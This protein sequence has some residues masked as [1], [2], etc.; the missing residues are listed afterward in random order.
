MAL[1]SAG[2]TGTGGSLDNYV[3]VVW[4]KRAQLAFEKKLVAKQYSFDLS[5]MLSA[6]GG[7]NLQVPKL[8]NRT[9]ATRTLTTLTQVTPA[10]AT[11]GVFSMNVQTW[12]VDPEAVSFALSAQTKLFLLTNLEHKM[13]ESVMRKFDT[14]LLANYSSFTTTAAGTD[15]AATPASPDDIF[16][17]LRQLDSNSVPREDRVIILGPKTFWRF[18]K[19]NTITSRDWTTNSG[20]ETGDLPRLAGVP[21]YM[22]Q[23]VPT[24]ATGS[25]VNLVMHKEALAYA[26]AQPIKIEM[27]HDVSWLQDVY[28]SNMVYGTGCYRTDSIV[29]VYGS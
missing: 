11:E 19:N 15:D 6:Q 29:P 22:S 14:D 9:A 16:E 10:G 13:T 18:I 4:T 1:G 21:V 26:I 3:P 12:V 28:V 8:A 27:D 5:D 17:G 2:L 7:D 20:K 25:E 23:N 24:T